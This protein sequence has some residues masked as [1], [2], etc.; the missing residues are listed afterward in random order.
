M[1]SEF[2]V[3]SR[4]ICEG[5]VNSRMQLWVFLLVLTWPERECLVISQE[6]YYSSAF[7]SSHAPHEIIVFTF[8][9]HNNLIAE[10]CF[11][12]INAGLHAA[13]RP[14]SMQ[15]I[16]N[17]KSNANTNFYSVVFCQIKV[18]M[19][20]AEKFNLPRKAMLELQDFL[21]LLAFVWSCGGLPRFL[22]RHRRANNLIALLAGAFHRLWGGL[23]NNF[24]TRLHE[25]S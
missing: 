5:F 24:W 2:P 6:E 3:I 17:P 15:I 16:Q 22:D 1:R 25:N 19:P 23:Q 20:F 10:T 14:S 13:L 12:S 9:H 8:T 7:V 18:T 11:V 4:V 21:L